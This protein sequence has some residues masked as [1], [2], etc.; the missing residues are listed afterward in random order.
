MRRE[1]TLPQLPLPM[2][3]IRF[4]ACQ[5]S[6]PAAEGEMQIKKEPNRPSQPT[7]KGRE[8][9]KKKKKK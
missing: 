8:Q 7:S 3:A 6:I 9:T 5:F 4:L 1:A 2:T